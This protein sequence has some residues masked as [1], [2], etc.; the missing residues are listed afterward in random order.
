[1]YSQQFAQ[2]GGL[3]NGKTL[4]PQ[5]I[6]SKFHRDS[7]QAVYSRW[8]SHQDRVQPVWL[9]PSLAPCRCRRPVSHSKPANLL[10]RQWT[11]TWWCLLSKKN[12][13]KKYSITMGSALAY[14]RLLWKKKHVFKKQLLR[15]KRD[16]NIK[17]DSESHRVTGDILWPSWTGNIMRS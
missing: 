7:D 5:L 2:N 4:N 1:M 17:R 6:F 14:Q 12:T 3:T 16:S 8:C 10:W 11:G 9:D 13:H 15:E